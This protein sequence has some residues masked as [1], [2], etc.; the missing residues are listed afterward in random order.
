MLQSIVDEVCSFVGVGQ[1]SDPLPP[2]PP[3]SE[4][5]QFNRVS[6]STSGYREK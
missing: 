1:P 2:R 3:S 4:V 5:G 6:L